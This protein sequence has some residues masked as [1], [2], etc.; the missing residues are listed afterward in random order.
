ML[1]TYPFPQSPLGGYCHV[2]IAIPYCPFA[3]FVGDSSHKSSSTRH[4]LSDL[5]WSRSLQSLQ[6]LQILQ[7]LREG[8]RKVRGLQVKRAGVAEVA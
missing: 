8:W 2:E 7:A 6:E 4:F 1:R 5:H 3:S